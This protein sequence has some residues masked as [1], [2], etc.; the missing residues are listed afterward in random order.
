MENMIIH[1]IYFIRERIQ[2]KQNV[3]N[4]Y[5]SVIIVC[6]AMMQLCWRGDTYQGEVKFQAICHGIHILYSLAIMFLVTV[7]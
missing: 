2:N 6:V 1:N 5:N 3:P 7:W 4:N